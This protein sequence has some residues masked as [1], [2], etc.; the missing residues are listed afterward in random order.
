MCLA[1]FNSG[2]VA[3]AL[4][5]ASGKTVIIKEQVL[6]PSNHGVYAVFNFI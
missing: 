5:K 3:S 1:R 4:A 2:S 6:S